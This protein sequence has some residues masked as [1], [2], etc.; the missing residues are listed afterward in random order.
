MDFKLELIVLP[1]SD[2]DRAKSFYEKLGFRL[3]V[4]NTFNEQY[5]AV[6]SGRAT[7][8]PAAGATGGVWRLGTGSGRT[9]LA[10]I[11]GGGVGRC[12]G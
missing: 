11:S 9:A 7:A 3:D 6:H 12:G 2:V 1:V 4:D 8:A 10:E 5:R